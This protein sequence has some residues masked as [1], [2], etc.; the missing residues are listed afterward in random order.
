LNP[1]VVT[2]GKFASNITLVVLILVNLLPIFGSL[3][4]D[5]NV[6]E[7]VVLYWFENVVLGVINVM[8]II[9]CRPHDIEDRFA[10]NQQKVGLVPFFT[11]HYGMFCFVH[12][13][14]VFKLFGTENVATVA[15][16]SPIDGFQSIIANL[17]QSN[18][19]IFVIAVIGSH[20][21]SFF[22]NYLGG[23]EF[24]RTT[25]Q[26]LMGAPYGRIF[27]LHVA[28]IAGGFVVQALGQQIWMLVLLVLGKVIMDAK[29][30]LRS[31]EKLKN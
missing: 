13:I 25:P 4:W 23:G 30:H 22:R 10:I 16:G 27:V 1:A 2:K 19:I 17:F 28:I 18:G 3:V 15:S 14:F 11:I 20:M 12:G 21:F 29:L 8:K 26:K 9:C 31:H 24:G 6:F 5:W 7:I